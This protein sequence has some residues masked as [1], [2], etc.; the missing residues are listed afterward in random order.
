MNYINERVVKCRDTRDQFLNVLLTVTQIPPHPYNARFFHRH[1]MGFE[2]PERD[3]WWSVFLHY[4]Y[5]QHGA[6]DRLIELTWF[7]RTKT[8]VGDES[9]MLCA[10]A[11]A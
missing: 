10:I 3:A 2:L 1:L 5:G 6:V 9:V 8:H 4:Q 7:A 11:L